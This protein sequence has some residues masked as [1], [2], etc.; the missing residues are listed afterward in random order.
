MRK[1]LLA[2]FAVAAVL[3][4]SF[5]F[6][7]LPHHTSQK[8]WTPDSTLMT[9]LTESTYTQPKP[10]HESSEPV[11]VIVLNPFGSSSNTSMTFSPPY[12]R[13]VIGVNNTVT[14]VND[15][16]A[17]HTVTGVDRLFDYTLPHGTRITDVFTVPGTYRYTCYL[18]SW[19]TGVV[20]VVS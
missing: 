14:W 8:T 5:L 9:T 6:L 12:V 3:A 15:D 11:K 4:I 19:M 16:M 20:E 18:H 7:T 1:P 10:L 2:F 17:V 13:L